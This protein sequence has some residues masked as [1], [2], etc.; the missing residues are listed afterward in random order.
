VARVEE[1]DA[2][3][4][5]DEVLARFAELERVCSPE[6]APGEPPRTTAEV[7]A[8]IRHPPEFV[9][10][11]H[12]LA[13]DEACAGLWMHGPAATFARVLVHPDHRRR[14]LGALLVDAVRGRCKECGVKTL[15]ADHSTPAGAAFAARFGAVDGQSIVRS[16]LDLRA[17]LPAP[18]VPDGYRLATWL[19]RVPDEHVLSF[20]HARAAMDDAPA[21][22]GFEMPAESVE[23]IRAMEDS[24][25]VRN[26]ELR[27]TV[28]MDEAG[29]VA[30][31][32]DLRVSPGSALVFT[33]DTGTV[34]AHRGRGLARAVKLESLRRVRVDHPEATV[35]TTMNAEENVAM[36]HINASIG[37][38]PTVTVTQVSIEV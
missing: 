14:G 9:E 21:P 30:S 1:I 28:A 33:D 22:E 16:V 18:V 2:R 31:F 27:V 13:G 8:F 19:A 17:E 29:E 36:R 34:A 35:A 7:I 3:T 25:I 24:L 15:F 23:R 32:T 37:F 10:T 26:R 38:R 12:W 5:A 11:F 4:A 20:A 6:L